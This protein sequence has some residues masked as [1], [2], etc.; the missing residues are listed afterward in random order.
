M[1]GVVLKKSLWLGSW[2]PRWARIDGSTL[3]L[4]A[5]ATSDTP[6]KSHIDLSAERFAEEPTDDELSL[7]FMAH[8][9]ST[10][11]DLPDEWVKV[12]LKCEEP[13]QCTAWREAIKVASSQVGATAASDDTPQDTKSSS[14]SALA[15][16]LTARSISASTMS[17][18]NRK[19]SIFKV[20]F[21]GKAVRKM[22]EWQQARA[23]GFDSVSE[24]KKK[25]REARARVNA[26]QK[27]SSLE[28]EL[29]LILAAEEAAKVADKEGARMEIE[30]R[31]AETARMRREYD[32]RNL[33]GKCNKAFSKEPAFMCSSCKWEY[34]DKCARC[35]SHLFH[36]E[37]CNPATICSSCRF[38]SGNDCV[39]C[40]RHTFSSDKVPAIL[41]TNCDSRYKGKCVSKKKGN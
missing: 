1:E 12:D 15:A 41:C 3:F 27:G 30:K 37:R 9:A 23:L 17:S 28:E 8:V 19:S 34:K 20:S 21:L 5:G 29:S 14:S 24:F 26:A 40:G 7:S 35:Y 36:R 25:T 2:R 33:A 16:G 39:I 6:V 10:K 11:A 31:K 18:L 13:S 32:E 38:D 22:A 4:H